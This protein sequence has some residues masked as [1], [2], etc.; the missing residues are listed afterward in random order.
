[1]QKKAIVLNAKDNVATALAD[2]EAGEV[3]EME[4]DQVGLAHTEIR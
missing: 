3:V 2:M 1:M 4:A